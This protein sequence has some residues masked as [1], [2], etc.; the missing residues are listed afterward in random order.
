[1][2]L[3]VCHLRTRDERAPDSDVVRLAVKELACAGLPQ[4][5]CE[6]LLAIRNDSARAQSVGA[7]LAL[8]WAL[9]DGQAGAHRL[10]EFPSDQQ[11]SEQVRAAMSAF[12]ISETGRP[13]LT[14][15]VCSLSFAH[16]EGLAVCALDA[17]ASVGVDVEPLTRTTKRMEEIVE[18]YFSKAEQARLYLGDSRER[19]F[20]R[21]WTRKEALGKAR[22]TGLSAPMHLLD[23]ESVCPSCF[24]ERQLEGQL[25]TVCCMPR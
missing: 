14:A 22:G 19:E 20:L 17:D 3:S 16:S 10:D 7:R 4:G 13:C 25:I 5:E 15:H 12:V 6:R 24:V 2:I 23:T 11:L 1:M 8:L 18:R 21:V 9:L